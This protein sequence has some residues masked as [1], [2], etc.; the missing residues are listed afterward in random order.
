MEMIISN[1]ICI[2]HL[3]NLRGGYANKR[4]SYS[5]SITLPLHLPGMP[6]NKRWV[7]TVTEAATFSELAI[8]Q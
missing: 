5:S 2:L 7:T 8:C 1:S 3:Q 6:G 4:Y